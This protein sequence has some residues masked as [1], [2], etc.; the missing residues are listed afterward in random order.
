VSTSKNT[1]T[2]IAHEPGRGWLIYAV[3]SSIAVAERA[4]ADALTEGFDFTALRQARRW[5]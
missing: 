5:P 1:I 2:V 3:V 4:E